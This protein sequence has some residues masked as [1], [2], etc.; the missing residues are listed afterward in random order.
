MEKRFNLFNFLFGFVFSWF[1][2]VQYISHTHREKSKYQNIKLIL[3]NLALLP[4][5][6]VGIASV[7]YAMQQLP[8]GVAQICSDHG[9]I[10]QLS[11][12]NKYIVMIIL[13]I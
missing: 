6:Y 3:K 7:C 5:L 12:L 13:T 1:A 2:T 4:L 8:S 11:K 10:K 9:I